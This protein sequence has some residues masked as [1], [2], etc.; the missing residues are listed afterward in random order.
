MYKRRIE[1]FPKIINNKT[2]IKEA[3]SKALNIDEIET[4]ILEDKI[5]IS[6]I[7]EN[8]NTLLHHILKFNIDNISEQYINIIKYYINNNIPL[9]Y[10]NNEGEYIIHLAAKLGNHEIIKELLDSEK[11]LV[12]VKDN[13]GNYPIHYVYGNYTDCPNDI[14]EQLI[15]F[16]DKDTEFKKFPIDRLF[17]MKDIPEDNISYI[18]TINRKLNIDNWFKSNII[19]NIKDDIK[20]DDIFINMKWSNNDIYNNQIEVKC[21]RCNINNFTELIKKDYNCLKLQDY[22]GDTILHKIINSLNYNIL[23][24]LNEKNKDK[25]NIKRLIEYVKLN[26]RNN[27]NLKLE[28]ILK[29]KIRLLTLNYKNYDQ[30]EEYIFKIFNNNIYSEIYKQENNKNNILKNLDIKNIIKNKFESQVQVETS[31]LLGNLFKTEESKEYIKLFINNINKN[32]NNINIFN[33]F[34]DISD[35]ISF[36]IFHTYC[37]EIKEYM[38]DYIKNKNRYILDNTIATIHWNNIKSVYEIYTKKFTEIL[39]N[40]V[41]KYN[42][43]IIDNIYGLYYTSFSEF[44]D[45]INNDKQCM[46]ELYKFYKNDYFR[47]NYGIIELYIHTRILLNYALGIDVTDQKILKITSSPTDLEYLNKIININKIGCM[48]RIF[49]VNYFYFHINIDQYGNRINLM[50]ENTTKSLNESL[51]NSNMMIENILSLLF[52]NIKIN[53]TKTIDTKY[54]DIFKKICNPANVIE[55]IDIGH[56]DWEDSKK[57]HNIQKYYDE[58][59]HNISS[60]YVIGLVEINTIYTNIRIIVN[61]FIKKFNKNAQKIKNN[62]YYNTFLV[63][64]DITNDNIFGVMLYIIYFNYINSNIIDLIFRVI[65]LENIKDTITKDENFDRIFKE[66]IDEYIYNND[67]ENNVYNK[68]IRIIWTKVKLMNEGASVSGAWGSIGSYSQVIVNNKNEFNLSNPLFI[69]S[70]YGDNLTIQTD[71]PEQVYDS[72]YRETGDNKLIIHI[73]KLF[74]TNNRYERTTEINLGAL[75]KVKSIYFNNNN[76]YYKKLFEVTG[77]LKNFDTLLKKQFINSYNLYIDPDTILNILKRFIQILPVTKIPESDISKT[78]KMYAYKNNLNELYKEFFIFDNVASSDIKLTILSYVYTFI[79]KNIKLET[80][81][82]T[83]KKQKQNYNY[84]IFSEKLRSLIESNND[85]AIDQNITNIKYLYDI[86]NLDTLPT[87]DN[88]SKYTIVVDKTIEET[89]NNIKKIIEKLTKFNISSSNVPFKK[90]EIDESNDTKLF[91]ETNII[92]DNIFDYKNINN[93]IKACLNYRDITDDIKDLNTLNEELIEKNKIII[94]DNIINNNINYIY[95]EKKYHL[96]F[97]NLK[98]LEEK[99]Y[100]D[101][102]NN[103][104][105]YFSNISDITLKNMQF[106]I[107]YIDNF[108]MNIYK[109]HMTIE[110]Y[111]L[112][113]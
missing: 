48:N 106:I 3:F 96:Q 104:L 77:G 51:I 107:N 35:I 80:P 49:L 2:I 29:K 75:D 56:S 78:L 92:D 109:L 11:V 100:D 101:I 53:I 69:I 7:D 90:Y 63:K 97:S 21:L 14:V 88:I 39:K 81:E 102:I 15:K 32:K 40:I 50:N 103:I 5:P 98:E 91:N 105:K 58:Y 54:T 42:S 30:L 37:K 22:N 87:T 110:Q 24:K 23:S 25:E 66:N 89:K 65:P 1:L 94:K 59:Y 45:K 28:D 41:K 71:Y 17:V 6:I 79:F 85:T 26:I 84:N 43:V 95:T 61:H 55:A 74:L 112:L 4:L 36:E 27:N 9:N 93:I 33:I 10:A 19:P 111:K 72:S 44:V 38:E 12:N 34:T 16:T 76:K 113:S 31:E 60:K 83:Y 82:S 18:D 68:I 70:F 52:L 73:K 57:Q 8:K 108:I 64:I 67:I 13:K 99:L 62:I 47:M 20:E 86:N 46:Y